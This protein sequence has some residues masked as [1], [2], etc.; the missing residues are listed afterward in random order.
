[1]YMLKEAEIIPIMIGDLATITQGLPEYVQ[2][3][4][5][6]ANVDMILKSALLGASHIIHK[7]LT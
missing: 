6:N 7:F 3:V 5:Q 1:M 2:K 4:S